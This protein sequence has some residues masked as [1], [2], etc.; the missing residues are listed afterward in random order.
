MA[1]LNIEDRKKIS[2]LIGNLPVEKTIDTD[3]EKIEVQLI[4]AFYAYESAQSNFVF[5]HDMINVIYS[6]GF[7]PV[8]P[9]AYS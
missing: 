9:S 5:D 2:R 7:V 8:N 6:L 1:K 4:E 3:V